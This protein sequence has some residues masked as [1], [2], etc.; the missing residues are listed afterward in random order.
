MSVGE[1]INQGQ[2][3]ASTSKTKPG[4]TDEKTKLGGKEIQKTNQTKNPSNTKHPKARRGE[5]KQQ[6]NHGMGVGLKIGV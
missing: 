3:T 5:K 4:E 2:K 1:L 6:K